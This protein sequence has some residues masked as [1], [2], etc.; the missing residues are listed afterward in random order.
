[1]TRGWAISHR[2]PRNRGLADSS[3][4]WPSRNLS[5]MN[6]WLNHMRPQVVVA[7]P[8]Q[9]ADDGSCRSRCCGRRPRPPRRGS[10]ARA[11]SSRSAIV[12]AV[13]EV[14]IIAREEEDEVAGRADI[15]P[16]PA[17]RPAAARRRGRTRPAWPAPRP[18]SADG[19]VADCCRRL[20]MAPLMPSLY[21]ATCTIAAIVCIATI[22]LRTCAN[23]NSS[24]SSNRYNFISSI[25]LF[26]TFQVNHS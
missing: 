4:C 19:V 25:D 15:E 24:H 13:G 17:A 16:V 23:Y 2:P 8:H 9:H 1:M 22:A 11:S 12:A 10:F 14:L 21:G 18:A 7:L 6:G 5:R 3:T 20:S 26:A